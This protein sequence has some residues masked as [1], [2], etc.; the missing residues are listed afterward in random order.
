MLDSKIEEKI[1]KLFLFISKGEKEIKKLK[2]I[3]S[4]KYKINPV[5]LF[6]K[7]D[8]DEKGFFTKVDF[9]S[10][11][12]NF[13]IHFSKNDIDIFF[14]F[15]D[16]NLDNYINLEEFIDFLIP[17]NNINKA[18]KNKVKKNK[19]D[20][21]DYFI[22][23]ESL[24]LFL[25]IFKEEKNFGEKIFK[26]VNE[27]KSS[28]DFS[29]E[30]L[31]NILRGYLY[32]SIE[33]LSA[34]FDRKYIK[35]KKSDVE[36]ILNRIDRGNSCKISFNR[37]QSFF[38]FSDKLYPNNY[39]IYNT[40]TNFNNE[41][42]DNYYNKTTIITDRSNNY[43]TLN[44]D[45]MCNHYIKK[46]YIPKSRNPQYS[47][48]NYESLINKYLN[49]EKPKDSLKM[50]NNIYECIHHSNNVRIPIKLNNKKP[51]LKNQINN[52]TNIQYK[53]YIQEKRNNSLNNRI[54]Q[55]L[56]NNPKYMINSYF[57]KKIKK[58]S[59]KENN[60]NHFQTNFSYEMNNCN[61]FPTEI[62]INANNQNIFNNN[63]YNNTPIKISESVII[64]P[65]IERRNCK[66]DI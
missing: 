66:Y 47:Y 27:V 46:K 45:Y 53:N 50:F 19:N 29:V 42:N 14:F 64:K 61:H 20:C 1:G 40:S 48:S 34:F 15:F 38:N 26:I 30:S 28:Q 41:S 58:I 37:F 55:T 25:Q 32:I 21:N 56:E 39:Q 13:K 10:Y 6:N 63:I 65:S 18:W 17:N 7:I 23:S 35:Y 3:I 22:E 60:Y 31:F 12:N 11:L 44:N 54:C 51:I 8:V 43:N 33:S 49:T 4:E 59:N 2:K 5:K 24:N 36:N 57:E 52:G 16:T 9:E 62:S